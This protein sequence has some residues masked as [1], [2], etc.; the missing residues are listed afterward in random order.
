MNKKEAWDQ[1]WATLQDEQDEAC[2]ERFHLEELLKR[3]KQNLRKLELKRAEYGLDVPLYLDNQIVFE[4]K[5]IQ[6][7]ENKLRWL[8]KL[9]EILREQMEIAKLLAE[10]EGDTKTS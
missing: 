9:Q 2:S 4:Q 10:N 3:R 1:R 8:T 5:E 7:I 6:E